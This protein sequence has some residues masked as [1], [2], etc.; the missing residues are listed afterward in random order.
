MQAIATDS[1]ISADLSAVQQLSP[2]ALAYL[3][4]VVYELY[5][6]T[7]YLLPPQRPAAYHRQVVAQARAERQ[8]EHLQALE[9]E[10]TEAEREILRRGR[11]AATRGP[12]RLAATVYRQATS[13]ETLI[14]YLYLTDPNRLNQLLAKLELDNLKS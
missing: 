2:V 5:L 1:K 10:F 6:R 4:D 3:G 12:Q 7:H 9:L 8:A 11:N 13:L 14:G